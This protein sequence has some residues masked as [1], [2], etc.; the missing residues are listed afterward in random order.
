MYQIIILK[1]YINNLTEL[2]KK[3]FNLLN[4]KLIFVVKVFL[5]CDGVLANGCVLAQV[6]TSQVRTRMLAL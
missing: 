1:S 5:G 4:E 6:G 3:N 2:D